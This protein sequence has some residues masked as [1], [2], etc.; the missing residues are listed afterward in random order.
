[1]KRL[2]LLALL[3]ASCKRETN[4]NNG[5]IDRGKQLMNQY[6]CGACHNIRGVPGA[7][8]M[9]G[10][11]L[12]HIAQRET[13]AGKYPNTPDVMTK[14]LQNPQAMDPNSTMP[15]LGVTPTDARDIAAFL[16]TL[17]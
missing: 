2:L 3:L 13:L 4:A 5:N 15:N 14:W 16:F 6:G 8:G 17:K 7:T 10:P 9:V 11:P 12:D 1:M